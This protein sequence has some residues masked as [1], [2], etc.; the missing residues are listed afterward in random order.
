MLQLSSYKNERYLKWCRQNIKDEISV[1]GILSLF[2]TLFIFLNKLIF[3]IFFCL[4]LIFRGLTFR[5]IPQKKKFV[6]TPR[7]KRLYTTLTLFCIILILIIN[8]FGKANNPKYAF[9][10]FFI[11]AFLSNI[12]FYLTSLINLINLPIEKAISMWYIND[13]K[14]LLSSHKNL[15]TIGITGSYGK[16]SSKY[17]LSR[18]LSEKYNILMT[19]ESYN[20]TMGVVK[21]IREQLN[22][23]HA[24]FIAEMGA[25]KRGDIK[26]I[27]DIVKPK[28]GLLTSIG[29]CHLETFKT[30][31][32]VADT[33]FE[34]I[35]SL[36]QDGLAFLNFDNEIIENRKINKPFCSYGINNNKLSFWAENIRYESDGVKFEFCTSDG[37][38]LPLK[39]KLLGLHNVLNITG[40]AGIAI[41]LSIQPENIAYAVSRLTAVPHRLELKPKVAGG[42]T[43]IDDA[44]NSNPA[45]ASEALTVLSS[46]KG[47]KR[48]LVTP[49][50][51]EMGDK[52]YELNRA[53]GEKAA[54]CCDF[55]VAVGKK[56]SV[57]IVEGLK[58]KGFDK[59]RLWV[60][61]NLNEGLE[62]L[63][64]IADENSVV[65]FENDLPDN[66][67]EI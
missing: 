1:L 15:I 14:R 39:T 51:V 34:L 49:G 65:L 58:N 8:S 41:M 19:P 52:E 59:D 63:K 57:P 56:R 5:K 16:T 33:K 18:I 54:T 42:Y 40:A 48:I 67:E 17:I 30:I 2:I 26:E 46:F 50:M 61:K 45:G 55:V 25:K 35:D 12:P 31:E 6:I 37:L 28:F 44:Y 29:P 36:P 66:Y 7:V 24:I 23:S 27:C 4:I 20:T 3:T 9:I 47:K 53:F 10:F 60:V 11:L 43:V 64:K 21:T 62:V 32:N 22:P 13:A 38:V